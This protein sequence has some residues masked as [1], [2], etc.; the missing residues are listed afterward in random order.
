MLVRCVGWP[1]V[2]Y[3]CL[4]GALS[5]RTPRCP[6][7]MSLR[8]DPSCTLRSVPGWRRQE[9]LDVFLRRSPGPALIQLIFILAEPNSIEEPLQNMSYF[10][11]L[12]ISFSNRD[13]ASIV[14]W[15]FWPESY[16]EISVQN[17]LA[18]TVWWGFWP[19]L[20][21][22]ILYIYNEQNWLLR[23]EPLWITLKGAVR[24]DAR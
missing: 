9:W 14:Q 21:S 16:S 7:R 3:V 23:F 10:S 4:P 1:W 8:S 5:Q 2:G 13:R 22:D 12:D 19:E 15:G 20:Y 11:L 17:C 6:A 24:R 18:R